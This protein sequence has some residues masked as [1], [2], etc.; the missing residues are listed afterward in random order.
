MTAR[1]I[2]PQRRSDGS[3]TVAAVFGQPLGAVVDEVD[4]AFAE[5]RDALS[6]VDMAEDLAAEPVAR[7][8]D[9]GF[10][11]VFEIRPDSRLWRDWA[12][13]LVSALRARLGPGSFVGFFDDVSGRMH[14][15]ALWDQASDEP[16]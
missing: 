4:L 8:S 14:R 16:D 6:N 15:A 12:V 10:R 2:F 9:E 7:P 1:Q 5:W 11:V 13:A 3:A